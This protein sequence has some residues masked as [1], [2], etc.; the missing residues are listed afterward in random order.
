MIVATRRQPG[1]LQA[2]GTVAWV[3]ENCPDTT[4]DG[5]FLDS[6]VVALEYLRVETEY[7]SFGS[8]SDRIP[9]S[10]VP[11]YREKAARIASLL[12]KTPAAETETVR[13][14][15][16]AAL[17]D[18]LPEVRRAVDGHCCRGIKKRSSDYG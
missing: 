3:L 10:E 7:R 17:N 6:I 18:P 9:Y 8:E 16:A 1:L 14:W 12:Q 11:E 15:L 13:Q 2:L 4:A 5:H